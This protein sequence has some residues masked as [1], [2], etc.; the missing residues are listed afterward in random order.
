M[1]NT[2]QVYFHFSLLPLHVCYMFRL[3]LRPSSGMC[4]QECTIH[5]ITVEISE[6]VENML[7]PKLTEEEVE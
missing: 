7:W 3:V 6:P 5:Y 1:S 2:T 4:T